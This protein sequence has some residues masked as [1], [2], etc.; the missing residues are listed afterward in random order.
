MMIKP[1]ILINNIFILI[2]L[3]I[4]QSKQI[5]L[6]SMVNQDLDYGFSRSTVILEWVC[7]KSRTVTM[8]KLTNIWYDLILMTD[9]LIFLDPPN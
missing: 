8:E 9:W 2:K 7:E 4:T 6:Q 1:C 3:N 5:K